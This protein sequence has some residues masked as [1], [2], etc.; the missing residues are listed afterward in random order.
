MIPISD[1]L[2]YDRDSGRLFYTE[3]SS[4]G[5]K[6]NKS[7]PGKEAGHLDTKGYIRVYF[8]G[9][10]WKAHRLIATFFIPNPENKP[11]INHKNGVKSDNRIENLEWADASE[12]VQHSFDTGLN[13]GH[14]RNINPRMKLNTEDVKRVKNLYVKGS[15]QF[16]TRAL[17]RMFGVSHTAIRHALSSS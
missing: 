3:S 6:W 8:E 4:K 1:Y 10:S 13:V 14:H 12:N 9:R 17:G 15:A 5:L 16:G 7:H 2:S 11:Q